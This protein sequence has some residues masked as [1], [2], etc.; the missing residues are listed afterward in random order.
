MPV[1]YRRTDGRD[2]TVRVDFAILVQSP[3]K[4]KKFSIENSISWLRY[5]VVPAGSPNSLHVL[6]IRV[7][8]SLVQSRG[9]AGAACPNWPG[10]GAARARSPA[11]Y[12]HGRSARRV[13]ISIYLA[14]V[15]FILLLKQSRNTRAFV[16]TRGNPGVIVGLR[17]DDFTRARAFCTRR[18]NPSSKRGGVVDRLKC[19]APIGEDISMM[20]GPRY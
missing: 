13:V 8:F 5:I 16:N 10:A 3:K 20:Q 14:H 1:S 12:R 9:P 19:Y 4:I 15:Y 18:R 7:A 2:N 11:A 17:G 6:F